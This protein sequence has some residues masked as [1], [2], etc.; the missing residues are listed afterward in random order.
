VCDGHQAAIIVI[1]KVPRGS[2]QFGYVCILGQLP[3]VIY[4]DDAAC[5]HCCFGLRLANSCWGCVWSW[6]CS[7]VLGPCLRLLMNCV[8]FSMGTC[9]TVPIHVNDKALLAVLLWAGGAK[10]LIAT[11]PSLFA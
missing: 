1:I 2:D 7:K 8:V 10:A 11:I 4:Q 6:A 3:R 9:L 5:Q